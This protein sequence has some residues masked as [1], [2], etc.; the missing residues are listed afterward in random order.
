[1]AQKKLRSDLYVVRRTFF[2]A[3]RQWF[4]AGQIVAASDPVLKGRESLFR[5]FVPPGQAPE[6]ELDPEPEAAASTSTD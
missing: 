2:F 6:P 4:R 3:N 1:M 5:V